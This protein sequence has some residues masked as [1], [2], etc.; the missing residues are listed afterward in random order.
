MLILVFLLC[1]G[2]GA[3]YVL[4][5]SVRRRQ[6]SQMLDLIRFLRRE[7]RCSGAPLHYLLSS[8]AC[9]SDLPLVRDM[10]ASE[11]FD[12]TVAYEKAKN[13]SK[14]EMFFTEK[15]W[16]IADELFYSLG[17]G[18]GEAQETLL[19]GSELAFLEA[20]REVRSV[21][22]KNGKPAVVLGCSA[23]AVLVLMLL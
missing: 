12:L 9:P 10:D 16:G 5:L 20:E 8:T 21:I 14:S 18:D 7:I 4:D 15:E 17:Q 22:G 19:S 11:P 3:V 13:V 23:G 2:S 6:I 1:G